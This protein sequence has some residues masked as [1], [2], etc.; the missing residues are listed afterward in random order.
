MDTKAT[1]SWLKD[2]SLRPT[3]EALVMAAQ[4]QVLHTRAYQ[5][6][7]MRKPVDP[8]CRACARLWPTS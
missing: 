8:K 4:D 3:T 6:K 2:G 7:V 1:H 5:A